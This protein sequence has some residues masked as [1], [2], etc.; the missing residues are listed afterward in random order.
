[1]NEQNNT[2]I[3][4]GQPTQPDT[5]SNSNVVPEVSSKTGA[6]SGVQPKQNSEVWKYILIALGSIAA[7]AIGVYLVITLFA[8]RNVSRTVMVYMVGSNL[9]SQNGLASDELNGIG[10]PEL[11]A[12]N[13]MNVVLIAGGSK[14][15]KNETIEADE[16]SIYELGEDGFTKVK[17]QKKQNMGEAEVLKN[18]LNYVTEH[19]STDEYDL[20]FWNHGGAIQGAEYDELYNHDQLSIAEMEEA[21]KGAGFGK[22]RKLET[23]IFSTCLNG[24]IEVAKMFKDYA[25]YL[26]ASEEVSMSYAGASDFM[27]LEEVLPSDEGY[28]FGQKFVEKYQS[29]ASDLKKMNAARGASNS[30]YSTYSVVDL[31]KIDNVEKALEEFFSSIDTLGDYK[32]IA[33]AR[34]KL[35]QYAQGDGSDD[36]DMVDLYNLVNSLDRFSSVSAE[37]VHNAIEEAVVYNYATDTKSRGISVYF[38]YAGSEKAK[39]SFMK[40]YDDIA[41]AKSYSKFVAD[42]YSVQKGGASRVMSLADNQAESETTSSNTMEFRLKLSDDQVEDFAS[43]SYM[44]V[45]NNPDYPGY[46]WPTLIGGTARLEGNTLLADVKNHQLSIK[47]DDGIDRTIMVQETEA[48]DGRVQYEFAVTLE[49][50]KD[51]FDIEAAKIKITGDQTTGEV[52]VDSV[53]LLDEDGLVGGRYV[54]LDDYDNVAFAVSSFNI[55]NDDMSYNEN[56]TSNGVIQ[57]WEVGTDELDLRF[58]DSFEKGYEYYCVFTVRDVYNNVVHSKFVKLNN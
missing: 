51:D 58:Q 41:P 37:K 10:N 19:Y 47:D 14:R 25:R 34:A 8:Q 46:Y 55:I 45:R 2:T 48:A 16:T 54:S 9:E 11:V 29:K 40:Y 15:W 26:V 32:K 56:F 6:G 18:F 31:A 33:Q 13:G 7:I 42:F 36:Y 21:L 5:T 17:K 28:E 22:N 35:Y 53:R 49:K 38:P 12:E 39:E 27:F 44:V 30:I 4:S 43:A 3:V 50:L 20:I 57:G 52:K 1:M 23:V 24:S